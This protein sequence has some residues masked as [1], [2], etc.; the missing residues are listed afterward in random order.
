MNK[1]M[2]S[3]SS[4]EWAT[5]QTLFDELDSEFHFNL[6]PCSTHE[7]AKCKE[8]FTKAEDGLVQS[9]GGEKSILQSAIQKGASGMD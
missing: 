5:P 8:H 7:N 2:F 1:A 3:S 4:I 6:D 9:W